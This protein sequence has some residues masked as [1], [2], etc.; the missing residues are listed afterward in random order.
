MSI[1]VCNMKKRVYQITLGAFV[2]LGVVFGAVKFAEG[3]PD[4]GFLGLGAALFLLAPPL[5]GRVLGGRPY[6]L[7]IELFAFCILAYDFGC[8]LQ[9]FDAIPMLDKVSHFLSGFVFT[10]LGVCVYLWLRRHEGKPLEQPGAT[11]VAFG[12]FFAAFVGVVWEI[13]EFVGF[14]TIQLDSQ[15]HLTTGVFDTMYDLITCVV[16]SLICATALVLH[17]NRGVKTPSGLVVRDFMEVL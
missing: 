16:G 5:L 13:C 9:M 11:A 14:L 7:Y 15:H 4:R 8:V 6:L 2:A 10:T 1:E 17:F 12:V 3:L